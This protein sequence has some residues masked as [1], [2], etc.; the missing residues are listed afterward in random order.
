M[1]NYIC[2]DDDESLLVEVRH[3]KLDEI[4]GRTDWKTGDIF[5][6]EGRAYSVTRGID[7]SYQTVTLVSSNA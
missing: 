3:E 4:F 7:G 6:D 1:I 2:A 5:V